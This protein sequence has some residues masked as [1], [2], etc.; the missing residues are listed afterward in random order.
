MGSSWN[1]EGKKYEAKHCHQWFMN[2]KIQS[3]G[4]KMGCSFYLQCE[5]VFHSARI[6]NEWVWGGE[7]YI[8]LKINVAKQ[9]V[10]IL[11]SV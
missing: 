4:N 11:L 3:K 2:K 6:G 8:N 5:H 10:N 1:E 7:I 9:R